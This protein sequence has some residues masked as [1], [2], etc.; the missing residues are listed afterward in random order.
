MFFELLIFSVEH[1]NLVAEKQFNLFV[2]L[3]F[4]GGANGCFYLI[5]KK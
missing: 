1:G 3:I 2:V 5:R 4:G